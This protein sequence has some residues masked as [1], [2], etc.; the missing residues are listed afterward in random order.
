MIESSFWYNWAAA[1]PYEARRKP[2]L[3]SCSFT[4]LGQFQ[5]P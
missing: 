2:F 5:K 3:D 4:D 1:A